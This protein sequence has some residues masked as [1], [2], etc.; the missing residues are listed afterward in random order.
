MFNPKIFIIGIILFFFAG[1]ATAQCPQ[2]IGFD[3]GDFTNWQAYTGTNT[4]NGTF[5][6]PNNGVVPGIHTICYSKD[7]LTDPYGNFPLVSPNGSSCFVKLGNNSIGSAKAQQ[8]TYTFT[9]P[10]NNPDYSLIYYYAVVFQNPP[11]LPYQQPTFT[12]KVFD[13]TDNTYA[14]CGSYQF[15]ATS[16]LPGFLQSNVGTSVFYKPW[17][18]VTISLLGYAGK[19]LRLE[20]ATG[21]CTLGGHFGYAYIDINQNCTSPVSGN[22]YCGNTT[23]AVTLVAPAGFQAYY[24]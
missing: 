8:L 1:I 10:A 2:N 12:A 18:A 11:H 5:S 7:K 17:S 14:S 15:Q 21:N 20:F 19:T 4:S 23:G 16:S 24:W 6:F 13:V 22:V 3:F 9:V